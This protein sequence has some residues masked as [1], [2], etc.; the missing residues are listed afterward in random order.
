[1]ENSENREGELEFNLFDMFLTLLKRWWIIAVSGVAVAAI[2]F[3]Y[4]AFLVTPTYVSKARIL[5]GREEDPRDTTTSFTINTLNIAT[6]LTQEFKYLI[7]E[8]IVLEPVVNALE[9]STSPNALSNSISVSTPETNLRLLDI[10]VSA[11]T[12]ETAY[13]INN[14]LIKQCEEILPTVHDHAKIKIIVTT[15]ASLPTSPSSPNVAMY[16]IVGLFLGVLISA[17]VVLVYDM[18]I[19]NMISAKKSAPAVQAATVAIAEDD[20]NVTAT[21]APASEKSGAKS[22]GSKDK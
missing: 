7:K 16:T 18:V 1:M 19:K 10:S 20:T 5:V 15:P 2:A 11:T 9:L 12:P 8:P 14:E 21:N 22:P 6:D 17:A 13:L 4:F 3:V